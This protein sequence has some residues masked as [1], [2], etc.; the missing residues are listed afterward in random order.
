MHNSLR[1]NG[2]VAAVLAF[3]TF[4]PSAIA[5]EK[6]TAWTCQGVG[7]GQFEPLGDREG[8]A[9][10]V[11][12]Y[13]CRGDSGPQAGTV[14]TGNALW[15]WNGPKA[16]LISNSGVARKPGATNAY[17]FTEGEQTLTMTDGKVTGCT[18]SGRGKNVVATGSLASMAGTSFTCTW[19]CV[20]P[21]SQFSAECTNE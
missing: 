13:S 4:A 11:G 8:H 21:G 10:D 14:S 18:G 2:S 19:K 5:Q 9:L 15:E 3:A 6:T 20:G 12:Q 17:M 16:I 7:S 1:F